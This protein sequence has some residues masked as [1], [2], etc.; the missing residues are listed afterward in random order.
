MYK[1]I[2]QQFDEDWLEIKKEFEKDPHWVKTQGFGSP[3]YYFQLAQEWKD[4]IKDIEKEIDCFRELYQKHRENIELRQ[5][6]SK[7]ISKLAKEKKQ[8]LLT[9]K[10]YQSIG[11]K[12]S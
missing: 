12:Q 4:D 3:E 5:K 2:A 7:I 6:I 11:K 9:I 8:C 1:T 10:H